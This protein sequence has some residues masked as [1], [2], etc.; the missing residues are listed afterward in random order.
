M[1]TS[2]PTDSKREKGGSRY[3]RLLRAVSTEAAGRSARALIEV[4]ASVVRIRELVERWKNTGNGQFAGRLAEEWHAGSFNE[5]AALAGRSD[6]RAYTTESLGFPHDPAD[7][8]VMKRGQTVLRAQSKYLKGAARTVFSH[9]DPKYQG[10]K[11]LTPADQIEKVRDLAE[12]ASGFETP[13]DYA[14][15]AKNATDHLA[16]EGVKGRPL[17]KAEADR[18]AEKARSGRLEGVLRRGTFIRAVGRSAI[19]GAALGF[20]VATLRKAKELRQ[21]PARRLEAAKAILKEGTAA[22]AASA[23]TTAAAL[24]SE[25]T[26]LRLGLGRMAGVAPAIGIAAAGISRETYLAL[27]G[28]IEPSEFFARV[29]EHLLRGGALSAGAAA[30]AALGSAVLPGVGTAAGGIVGG[31]LGDLALERVRPAFSLQALRNQRPPATFLQT[32]LPGPRS[33]ETPEEQENR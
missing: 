18:L 8:V 16:V 20:S 14:D 19:T 28:E 15:V 11:R 13:R 3:A 1:K 21:D 4:E 17:S 29:R 9:A 30:G 12:K 26:L 23:F 27:K 5:A 7:V 22:A 33:N 25:R 6:L 31:L 10:L 32:A 2:K 24:T